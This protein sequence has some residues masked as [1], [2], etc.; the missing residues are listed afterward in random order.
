[1]T[2]YERPLPHPSY[3]FYCCIYCSRQFMLEVQM[4]SHIEIY[5]DNKLIIFEEDDPW[6]L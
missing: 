1:M 3:P 5:H 4:F 2:K 6:R